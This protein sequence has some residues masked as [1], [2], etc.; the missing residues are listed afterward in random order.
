MDKLHIEKDFIGK[1][2][3]LEKAK[4][5]LATHWMKIDDLTK[6]ELSK[7]LLFPQDQESMEKKLLNFSVEGHKIEEI[8]LL[9]KKN[10][11]DKRHHALDAIVICFLEEWAVDKSKRKHFRLPESI[12]DGQYIQEILDK[13]IPQKIAFP[14]AALLEQPVGFNT[15]H[16]KNEVF[17]RK[18]LEEFFKNAQTSN[19]DK[20]IEKI[21]SKNIKQE[22][23][24]LLRDCG[25]DI[26]S[27]KR[28]SKKLY[29]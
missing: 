1:E 14:K 15:N 10:R 28:T 19:I 20:I 8:P 6:T 11:N 25:R 22:L 5:V 2:F 21:I 13:I 3:K 23:K 27:F 18:Q 16:K 7:I 9:D 29:F 12:R 24:D 26:M 4:K 17:Q